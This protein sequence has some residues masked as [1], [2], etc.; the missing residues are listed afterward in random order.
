MDKGR[1]YTEICHPLQSIEVKLA[2]DGQIWAESGNYNGYILELEGSRTSLGTKVYFTMA[3]GEH[4]WN[5][6][7]DLTISPIRDT[8]VVLGQ[9]EEHMCLVAVDSPQ[10]LQ[11]QGYWIKH[12]NTAVAIELKESVVRT[13]GR[14]N[15]SEIRKQV[16]IDD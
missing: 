6:N 5:L 11:L 12:K 14:I 13:E 10:R 1:G 9:T 3:Y 2:L 4:K 15:Q 7:E 16:E 8:G